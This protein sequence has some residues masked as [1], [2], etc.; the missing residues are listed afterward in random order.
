MP[1]ASAPR[2]LPTE[3]PPALL[4]RLS[5]RGHA[6]FSPGVGDTDAEHSGAD[7]RRKQHD[8]HVWQTAWAEIMKDGV[9]PQTAGEK[10]CKRVE[11][12]FANIRSQS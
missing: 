8:E 9:A 10:A 5:S 1:Y 6:L 12:I 2:H 11:E 4:V 3:C 7:C